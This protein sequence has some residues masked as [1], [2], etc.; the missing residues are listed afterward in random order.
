MLWDENGTLWLDRVATQEV[1]QIGDTGQGSGDDVQF[2]PDGKLIAYIHNHNLYVVSDG[3]QPVALT[4]TTDPNLRNGETDWVYLEELAV[5]TNYSWAPDS[6]HI[7][8]LQM[9]ETKVPTYPIVDWIPTHATVDEQK[10]PQPGDPNPAVRLGIVAADGGRTKWIEL[11]E[12]RAN[13]DYIPRSGW[14]NA[15]TVWIETLRRDQKH[16][17]IWFADISTG[18]ATRALALTDAKFFDDKYDVEFYSPGNLLL[19]S[20]RSGFTHID[21]YTYSTTAPREGKLQLVKQVEDGAY[22]VSGVLSVINNTIYYM[23]NEGDPLQSQLWAVGVDGTNKHRVTRE[24]GTHGVAFAKGQ[25]IYTDKYSDLQTPPKLSICSLAGAQPHCLP[26]WQEQPRKDHTVHTPQMLQ[27]KAADGKTTLYASLL[28][29]SSSTG[30]ATVPLITNPYGGPGTYTVKNAWGGQSFYFDNLLAEHG[31]AVLHVDNRGMSGRGREFAQVAYHDFGKVQLADQLAA[32]DQVLAKY[33][34]LDARRLG[35]WGWSWGGTFTLNAM[36]HSARFSAG[37]SVAPVTDFRNYD[38]IYTERYLG[39]PQESPK[40]YDAAAVLNTAANLKGRL[41]LNHGTGDDNV[42]MQ[43]TVQFVER[44][45]KADKPYD[46]QI[47]PRKTHS[48]AGPADRTEL[49]ERILAHFE[50]YLPASAQ[51]Q[52]H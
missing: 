13:E 5:R 24:V 44:L 6:E 17:D 14:L 43:N 23:S 7:A 48:I 45:I 34:E 47:Y 31:Y 22:A 9:D 40:V 35:W 33:P 38:S 49:F 4:N 15:N 16:L 12:V 10:Y 50:Q 29:P 41:L 46:L 21:H 11:P 28:M 36:T 32:I 1:Q 51:G 42:H 19:T 8:Y 52:A 25:S 27:L 26:I 2:S 37:V 3:K 39:T 20:W 18:K 30:A